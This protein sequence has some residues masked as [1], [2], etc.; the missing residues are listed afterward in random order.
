MHSQSDWAARGDPLRRK[1]LGGFVSLRPEAHPVM[2]CHDQNTLEGE[3][4]GG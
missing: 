1:G 3:R 2:H 4:D